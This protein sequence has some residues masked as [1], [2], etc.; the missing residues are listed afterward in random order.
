MDAKIEGQKD[1]LAKVTQLASGEKR[2]ES[3]S[4]YQI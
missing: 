2:M 3:R 4:Q 1:S